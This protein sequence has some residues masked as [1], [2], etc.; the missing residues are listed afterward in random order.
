MY[1]GCLARF[2]DTDIKRYISA[3]LYKKYL[4][5]KGRYSMMVNKKSLK[6]VGCPFPDCPEYVDL[7][8]G[9]T[10]FVQCK[11]NHKFCVNCLEK[12]HIGNK[13]PT[14]YNIIIL[15]FYDY[16]KILIR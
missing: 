14:V 15:T 11:L 4:D 2:A 3:K 9:Q 5:Y 8:K 12:W 10:A 1:G 6:V 16:R 7:N 13:C